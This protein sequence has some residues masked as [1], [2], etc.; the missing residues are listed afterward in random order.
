MAKLWGTQPPAMR[1]HSLANPTRTKGCSDQCGKAMKDAALA[2]TDVQYI[3]AHG[4][5]TPLNDPNESKAIQA[6]SLAIT[7]SS[8]SVSST[9]SATG[10]M[11]GA[12]GSVEFIACALAIRDGQVPPTINYQVPDPEC[13]LD[14]TPNVSRART[15]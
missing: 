14:Y 6:R 7:R 10:H 8:L 2:P 4:T 11:L 3:N 5:S 12:A 15:G 1:T 13:D 9:K